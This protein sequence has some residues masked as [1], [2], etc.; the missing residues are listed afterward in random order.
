MR[1]EGNME[2]DIQQNDDGEKQ[3]GN[4]DP[5]VDYTV[6]REM[7][8][9]HAHFYVESTVQDKNSNLLSVE[10]TGCPA[11]ISI[12]GDKFKIVKGKIEKR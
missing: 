11:G 7:S 1:Q 8:T 3:V 10:C 6:E 9:N 12:D 5:F 2:K 4:V